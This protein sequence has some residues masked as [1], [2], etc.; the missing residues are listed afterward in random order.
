MFSLR[1]GLRCR[2]SGRCE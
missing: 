1:R 2:P